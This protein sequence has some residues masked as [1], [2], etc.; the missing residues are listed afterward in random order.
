MPPVS[1]DHSGMR[2]V[3]RALAEVVPER[4]GL[5][6]FEVGDDSVE[7]IA[8]RVN[9]WLALDDAERKRVGEALAARVHELWSWERVAEGVIAA[10]Q[11]RLDA[12]PEVGSG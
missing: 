8:E 6:S 9:G 12:L 5:L 7:A 11:G 2:E 4:A 3:S 10:S 1:A